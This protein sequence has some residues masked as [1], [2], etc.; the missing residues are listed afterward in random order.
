MKTKVNVSSHFRA[1]CGHGC[2]N[3]WVCVVDIHWEAVTDLIQVFDGDAC[4][5]VVA[6]SD[7]DRV[8]PSVQE[9]LGLLEKSSG[10]N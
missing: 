2:L 6:V 10:K 4:S 5:L 9:L 1:E 8:D 7:A 3:E